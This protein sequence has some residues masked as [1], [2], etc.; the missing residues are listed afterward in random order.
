MMEEKKTVRLL[1]ET[2]GRASFEIN[3]EC[4]DVDTAHSIYDALKENFENLAS[5]YQEEE[6]E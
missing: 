2:E 3:I 4:D 6:T 5:T 1:M